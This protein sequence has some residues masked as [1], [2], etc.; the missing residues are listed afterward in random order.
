MTAA[1]TNPATSWSAGTDPLT[2]ALRTEVARRVAAAGVAPS[3]Q[4]RAER[5]HTVIQAVLD[6]HAQRELAG[7]RAALAPPVE[8]AIAQAIADSLI[9]MGG[10]QPL[11]DDESITNI[12][13]NG[14]TVWVTRVDGRKEQVPPVAGSSE[15]LIELIRDIAARAGTDERRFDRGVPKVSVRLPDGS[16]MFATMLSREP[17][18][19]IR[20]HTLLQTSLQ[21]LAHD[22][23][24]M[25][26]GMISLFSAM[27][28]ARK[29]II[30]CGGTNSGKTTFLRA[31]AR[32]IPP[33]E[34]LIT[35][36]DTDELALDQD[37]DHPD[38]IALQAREANIE[39]EGAIDQAE[40]VRWGLRMSP[41]RVILGEAR[42]GEVI[43]LL[44]AMSQ[45]NDGSLATIHTSS[46]KQAF[47]RL[48]TYA[49]Q[50]VERLPFEATA[51]LI[52]GAVHFVVHLDWS[53][54][55]RRVVS[56]IR[57]VLHHEGADVISNE[58]F[59]PGLDR[60]AVPAAPLRSATFDELVA[61]GFRPE[62][63]EGW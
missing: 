29:N 61:A 7:G 6:E 51:P 34:R 30:I 2:T 26:P 17:S 52:A 36:E 22:K 21:Q 58:L 32:E 33:H 39:G 13:I 3:G 47:V 24:V 38:C 63:I 55:R 62:Q 49:A 8:K 16:R 43:P 42:G 10:L 60:R 23:G 1:L 9:G 40:L 35:I 44:N 57:E 41:D 50:A 56:S 53:G 46:S 18:V 45:G 14:S 27:V 54:D 37:P 28:K 4:E 11:L 20:R 12:F 19:S 25:P 15:E 5:V 31:L 48:Q 59:K